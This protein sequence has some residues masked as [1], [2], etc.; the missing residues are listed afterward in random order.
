MILIMSRVTVHTVLSKVLG[1]EFGIALV[2][3]FKI[4]INEF[5][6][7]QN[8]YSIQENPAYM[9]SQLYC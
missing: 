8:G 1:H 3:G 5:C 9:V 6:S 7:T 2:P 4:A